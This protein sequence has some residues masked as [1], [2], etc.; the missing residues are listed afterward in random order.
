LGRRLGHASADEEDEI[1]LLDACFQ[2]WVR[3]KPDFARSVNQVG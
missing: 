3:H 2:L 1:G